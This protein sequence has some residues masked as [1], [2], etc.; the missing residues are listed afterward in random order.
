M[1]M[2]YR[3]FIVGTKERPTVFLMSNGDISEN[4]ED[5]QLF[6]TADDA[7]FEIQRC[8]EPECF[9]LYG[10]EMRIVGV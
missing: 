3:R 9:Q 2:T 8:D 4:A 5:A 10:V 1:H 7:K 6:E